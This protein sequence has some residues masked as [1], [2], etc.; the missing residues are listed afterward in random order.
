MKQADLLTTLSKLKNVGVPCVQIGTTGGH[1]L[2][3]EGE[4][5]VDLKSLRHA[6]EHW[7]PDYMAGK[8]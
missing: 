7:L 5:T 1:V 3:I 8:A 2:K 6:H 4:R